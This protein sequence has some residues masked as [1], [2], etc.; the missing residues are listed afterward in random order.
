MIK[1]RS[2][3]V[4]SPSQSFIRVISQE[5][6]RLGKGLV[7][8]FSLFSASTALYQGSRFL[9]FLLVARWIGP[10]QFGLWNVLSL[11]LVYGSIV[12]LG[13]PNGMNREVPKLQGQ[14]DYEQ[15]QQI[16][17]F[18]F[19]FMLLV[20]GASALV[21]ALA[22]LFPGLSSQARFP[23]FCMGILFLTTQMYIYF[24]VL[25]RCHVRFRTMSLQQLIFALVNPLVVLPLAYFLGLNGFILGQ[26][27]MALGI[28]LLIRQ[29]APLRVA[30]AF[31]WQS[32]LPLAKIGLPILGAGLLY[33]LLT[34]VD[35]WVVLH[36]L[37]TEA[38]GHYGVPI[39]TLSLLSLLPKV[40]GGTAVPAHGLPFWSDRQHWFPRS[41]YY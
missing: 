6:K 21:I 2:Q 12:G 39:L 40:V 25:L 5:I 4:A 36:Y 30:A 11:I 1:T 23:L 38:L 32:F 14:G 13:V 7:G 19:G 26:A 27:L 15:A 41:P 20:S 3:T 8:E 24:Q 35:R 17:N 34:T 10:E 16:A 18:S 9:V 33:G 31:R 28:S 22:A 37:G 29:I